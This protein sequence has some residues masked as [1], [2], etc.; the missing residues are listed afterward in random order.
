VPTYHPAGEHG[1]EFKGEVY[2]EQ[3]RQMSEK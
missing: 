3:R 1:S 2:E